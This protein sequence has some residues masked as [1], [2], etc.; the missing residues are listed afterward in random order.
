MLKAMI[1]HP[2][3]G[4][5]VVADDVVIRTLKARYFQLARKEK[6]G[7]TPGITRQLDRLE[8]AIREHQ[9]LLR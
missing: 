3:S 1:K 5:V 9:G 7:R 2:A 6:L 8:A 4:A